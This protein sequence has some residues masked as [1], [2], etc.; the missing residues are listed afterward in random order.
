MAGGVVVAPSQGG[1]LSRSRTGEELDRVGDASIPRDQRRR[2]Q[3]LDLVAREQRSVPPLGI[4]VRLAA[5]LPLVE[6]LGGM[7]EVAGENRVSKHHA[8][9][10]VDVVEG[11]RGTDLAGCFARCRSDPPEHR[12]D[13]RRPHVAHE[14]V[15]D[16]GHDEVDEPRLITLPVDD[17]ALALLL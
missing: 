1:G 16:L 10:T 6:R 4:R 7:I 13:V 9:D 17:S 3:D 5:E 12:D 11:S 8:D 2:D 14:H 15:S